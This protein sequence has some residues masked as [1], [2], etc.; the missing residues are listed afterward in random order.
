[1]AQSPV[2]EKKVLE[3][4]IFDDITYVYDNNTVLEDLETVEE[5]TEVLEEISLLN[6]QYRHVHVELK[7]LMGDGY[8]D[9]YKEHGKRL[10][11][12]KTFISSVKTRIK[13][14]N[15]TKVD[16]EKD[17]LKSAL[18]IEQGIFHERFDKELADFRVDNVV[19][20]REKCSNFEALLQD[21]YRLFSKAKIGLAGNF[22]DAFGKTFDDRIATIRGKIDEGKKAVAKIESDFKKSAAKAKAEH[23][24]EVQKKYIAEQKFQASALLTEIKNRCDSLAKRCNRSVLNDLSDFQ[25]L[26]KQKNMGLVD[27]EMHDI[28]GRVTAYSKIAATCGEEK[29][30]M[31]KEAEALQ[32]DALKVRN[33]YFQELHAISVTRDISEE[34]LKNLS[35]LTIELDKF[36]GYDSKMDIYTFRSEF[37]KNVQRKHQ[38]RYWVDIL[39]KSYLSGPA[40]ILV[41]KLEDI[42]EVWK[43]LTE[44]YGNVKLLLQTKMNNLDKLGNLGLIEGDEKLANALAKI[45]NVMTELSTLAERHNLEYKLYVGGGLEKVYKLIGDDRERK[46]LSKNIKAMSSTSSDSFTP[47]SSSPDS[48]LLVEKTTWENLKRFLQKEHAIRETYTLN[49]KSKECLGV[50]NPPKDKKD[51]NPPALPPTLVNSGVQCPCHICGKMDHIVSTD[52]NGK[53]YID[54]FSC[55]IFASMTCEKRRQELQKKGFCFQC[56]KPGQKHR[57]THNC[58]KKYSCTDPSHA[59]FQK[60]LHV[61]VCERHKALQANIDLLEEFKRNVILKRSDNFRDFTKNISLVCMYENISVHTNNSVPSGNPKVLP[62]IKNSTIFQFQTINV[63]GHRFRLLYDSAGTRTLFKKSAIDI[64]ESLGLTKHTVPGPLFLRGAGNTKTE[65]PH[66]IYEFRLPLR[67]GYEATFTGMCLDKVTS[68]FPTYPL[69]EVEDDVR[70]QCRVQGGETLLNSL[71][72]LPK[73]VGGDV[74]ILIGLT[75]KKY[76]PKEVW[77]SPDGLFI[78]DSRF[79]SEDGTTGVVGGPH[80]KFT[81]VENNERSTGTFSFFSYTAPVIES[82]RSSYFQD[83]LVSSDPF[84]EKL[85]SGGDSDKYISE[86]IDGST[87]LSQLEGN[88]LVARKPPKCVKVFDEVESAGTEISYRCG[89]CRNCQECKKSLRIDVISIQEEIESEIVDQCVEVDEVKGEVVSKLPFVVN[90]DIRLQPNESMARRVYESQIR[91]LSKKPEDKQAAISFESKLQDLGFVDYLH[92]LTPEQQLMITSAPSRYFIPWRVVF[93]EHSVSTPCRLVF[94]ASQSTGDGVSLNSMLA[95]GVNNMNSLI[96]ILIRWGIHSCAFH[97]DISKMYNRVRLDESHWRFQLYLWDEQLRTGVHPIWKVIKTL[98]YGVRPSGQLAEVA[99]R[100]TAELMREKYPEAYS[101]IMNDIYVDDCLSGTNSIRSRNIATDQLIAALAATGFDVKGVTVSGELP[102]EHLSQDGKSVTVGGVKWFTLEDYFTLNI[103]EINFGKKH[104]GKRSLAEIGKIPEKLTKLDCVSK[105]A[106]IFDPTGRAAPILAGFKSDRSV[107]TERKLDWEDRI[108]DDLRKIWTDN[109]EMMQELKHV[110]FRRAVIP[111]DAVSTDVELLCVAD[112]SEILICLGIYARFLR[113]SGGHSCQLLFGRTKVVPKDMSIP[114]AELLAAVM[115]AS[116]THV[117]KTSL[118]KMVKKSWM[119]T[120]SQVALHW[121]NCTKT[122]LKLWVRNRVIEIIRLVGLVW[123]YVESKQ[124]VADIGTRK[125]ATLRCIGPD[126][127]WTNGYE[128]MRG[129]ES[130]FPIK[131]VEQVILDNEA[132]SEARKE[133]IVIDVLQDS[134][135][136]AHTYVPEQQV[137]EEVGLR[138]EFCNYVLDPNKFSFKKSVRV[139]ALVLIFVVKM[140]NVKK[141]VSVHVSV[142]TK[143]FNI[144]DLFS[145]PEGNFL[146]TTGEKSKGLQCPKGLVVELPDIMIKFALAYYF[147][148]STLEIKHFLPKHK[149]CNISKEIDG[150]MY[151]SGRILPDQKVEN[152]L[153]VADVSYDLS[154][155]TFCVP[156]VDRLS[157]VAYAI[158]DEVHWNSF[159]VRHGGIESVLREVQC[160]SYLIGGRKLVKDIKRSCIR[161]RILRKKRLEV[162]MGPKH[163]GNLCIAP[164]FHTTQ[165]DICGPLDSFSNANK[166]AKVK[167]WFVVFCCSA[168]GAVDIKIMEDYSTDAFIL[169]FIRF[170][171]RYGYPCSLLPDPGS[172]L[173]KGC[174]DM[175]LSFSDIQHKL[176]VEYG[177]SFQTCPVGAHYVHG[178][179][180]RKI[181]SI[182]SSLE[183]ELNNQRLSLVQWETLGQQIANSLNNL[184]LGLGNKSADLEN[185]DILTPNRLLLGRNNNRAPTAPLILSRDVKKIVQKNNDIFTGWFNSW[186]IS[187]VPTLVESPKW[188]KNDRNMA[189][190]DVVMFSKSEKEFENLYQYGIVTSVSFS[191]DGKIRKVEVEYTNPTENVKRK[192]IRGTRDLIVIHPV[193]ELGLSKELSDLANSHT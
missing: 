44:A 132:K 11:A 180:E 24:K 91:N 114:R 10:E 147:K 26:E 145:Q 133:K 149:Y 79:L 162:V 56:L 189:E 96:G 154:E 87:Q 137:P 86:E 41:E 43:K 186:L 48:E 112:A 68:T 188:F 25:I 67:D 6:K 64:L 47:D 57:D 40:F 120:D 76:F 168:T 157:P 37:E 94:D 174:K 106:E 32:A 74:D 66:G 103:S 62:D 53:Q 92:N 129:D 130:D 150:I 102:P 109:F 190:G 115:N 27:R 18:K 7:F 28:F 125:G 143:H 73:E 187:Y 36:Q 95:K 23:E 182:R 181:K 5:L 160:I 139:L 58:P 39:K 111:D 83:C 138:Y 84:G 161:C 50:K 179:V 177:V 101:V 9:A 12:M 35:N 4:Q 1:M 46:F 15:S 82:I 2:D 54:Y 31:L 49:Q 104:R 55:P 60:N 166:R 22:D 136:V 193:E 105:I 110:R 69:K 107:L 21:Y 172:Q 141:R 127:E 167:V 184:P 90:P 42:E 122:K 164:A 175:V 142:E 81:Q 19:E 65:C 126:G 34:K 52:Q 159:D 71:P 29:A 3:L 116:S 72:K 51:K 170:S 158:S 89:N 128:W 16:T 59:S 156:M 192:T 165:V 119:L 63:N 85:G 153:S 148:K 13:T 171:C 183:K 20:I 14:V 93:N 163:D 108:P 113:K 152:K 38:K 80:S 123:F 185:L 176:S 17:N 8:A 99:I 30:D 121:I 131:T 155:K 169:A 146:V 33:A 151:Y 100:K 135:F 78:S 191:K 144:P 97:T 77:Q 75:Y 61:L 118:G 117:V 178:K 124:N 173:V 140:L 88:V 134:Y 45:I 70:D 98:I